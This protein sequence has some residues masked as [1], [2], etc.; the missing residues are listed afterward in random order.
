MSRKQA[1][2]VRTARKPPVPSILAQVAQGF[3]SPATRDSSSFVT[4]SAI[5]AAVCLGLIAA[6]LAIYSQ[7]LWFGFVN[8]D[9]DFVVYNN[10][11]ILEGLTPINVLH[12]FLKGQYQS[13]LPLTTLSHL[14]DIE[15][16]GT[17]AGGH[18]ATNL[19]IHMGASALLFLAFRQMTEATWRSA[20]AAALFALHPLRVESVAWI[21]ERKDVLSGL[22][23][24]VLLLAYHHYTLRR[25]YR[26]YLM[27]FVTF[28][29]G[30]MAKATFV[31]VPFLLLLLDYWPCN[32]PRANTIGL[33][34]RSDWK[35][36][37]IEKIP[38]VLIS[39]GVSLATIWLQDTAIQSLDKVSLSTRLA[40]AVVRPATYIC[41]FFWPFGLSTFYPFPKDGIPSWQVVGSLLTLLGI[42][43]AA[44]I[45]RRRYP[46]FI[47]GWLWYL[48][49]LIPVIGLVQSGQQAHADRFTYLPLIGLA[50]CFAWGARDLAIA[51]RWRKKWCALAALVGLCFFTTVAWQQTRYWHDGV[52]L[53]TRALACTPSNYITENNLA[54]ALD[55]QGRTDE[56]LKYFQQSLADHPD[57]G[58]TLANYGDALRR[59]GKLQ[60]A[61]VYL[62]RAVQRDPRQIAAANNLG[63]TLARLGKLD[64]A[65]TCL[66]QALEREPNFVPLR[67]NLALVRVQQGK[68]AE[69][70][71]LYQQALAI[72]PSS[73]DA[74]ANLGITLYRTGKANEAVA[75]LRESLRLR[76]DNLDTLRNAA[77]ISA[78]HADVQLQ[79]PGEAITWA[80]RAV[81]LSQQHDPLM[82]GIL[83]GTYAN[84]GQFSEAMAAAT[85][86]LELARQQGR[87]DI[88]TM[89][90]DHLNSYRASRPIRE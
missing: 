51:M 71:V 69:A 35:G 17:W 16:Y 86:A 64:E 29:F 8:F 44:I 23:F 30:A 3:R 60:E 21:S 50:L 67:L 19:I 66:E 18:H 65:S 89:M 82:I 83:A 40:N 59:Q 1:A 25:T 42:S 85:R 12:A 39:L 45:W 10:R 53:F 4:R 68:L 37:A 57:F 78:T 7:T 61:L 22:C 5:P 9:D 48:G 55:R 28:T 75:K 2:K 80:Q 72:D 84:G 81:V 76:P 13:W 15:L 32:R 33:R 63:E 20:L 34:T 52:S 11:S 47:V 58:I 49:M 79:S 87:N 24:A 56:A 74:Y 88:A 6:L 36:L 90:R 41:Q 70:I 62:R 73:A 54:T 27:V 77:W 38:L 14:V 31:P 43:S 46:Y 26:R